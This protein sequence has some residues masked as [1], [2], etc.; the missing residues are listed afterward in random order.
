MRVN[1]KTNASI[2]IYKIV[3]SMHTHAHTISPRASKQKFGQRGKI[4]CMAVQVRS[5][6]FETASSSLHP[7]CHEYGRFVLATAMPVIKCV[8]TIPGPKT[9]CGRCREMCD[10]FVPSG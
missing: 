4:G 9:S 5:H 10:V 1:C 2:S 7:A 6:G 8:G 3:Y